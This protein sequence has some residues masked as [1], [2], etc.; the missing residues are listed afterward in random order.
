MNIFLRLILT[1]GALATQV[2]A[3]SADPPNLSAKQKETL[4]T[5]VLSRD[6][7]RSKLKFTEMKS[8]SRPTPLTMC[9]MDVDFRWRIDGVKY[10]LAS[11]LERQPVTGL[12][13]AKN[14]CIFFEQYQYGATVGSLFLSN[15]IAKSLTGLA[16]GFLKQEGLIDRLDIP[17]ATLIPA[18]VGTPMGE[19]TLRNHLRM[20]SGVKFSET[21]QPGDDSERFRKLVRDQGQLEA[22]KSIALRE[23]PQGEHFNYMG[24]SSAT[25]SL[26]V[27]ALKG[28]NLASYLGPRLWERIGSEHAAFWLEDNT[29]ASRGQCCV[30]ARPRDYLRLGILLANDGLD[31]T[32]GQQIIPREFLIETTTTESLDPGFAPRPGSW[33]YEN[34]FWII[35]G[36]DRQFALLGT[37]GQHIMV[38]PALKLVMVQFAVSERPRA[39]Q[40]SMLRERGALWSALVAHFRQRN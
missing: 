22:I 33:G 37:Y 38:D 18:L 9:S 20:G 40:T 11:Y 30:F 39:D 15:S 32:S 23:H 7:L 24:P 16:F 28:Q 34:Q 5:H 19:T 3:S 1:F 26:A 12:L 14:G 8:A 21:N 17:T 2:A 36:P 35:G 4:R 29:G 31:P 6:P 27:Q 25:L 13:I 10:T